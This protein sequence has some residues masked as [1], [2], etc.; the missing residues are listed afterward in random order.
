MPLGYLFSIIISLH[1]KALQMLSSGSTC[2]L[3]L[4]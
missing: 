3:S 4:K 1:T 2:E